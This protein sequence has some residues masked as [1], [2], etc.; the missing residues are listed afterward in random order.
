MFLQKIV[1]HIEGRSL[2]LLS[3]LT[4]LP[5]QQLSAV[6]AI[7]VVGANSSMADNIKRRLDKLPPT[8][9]TTSIEHEIQLALQPF[10]YYA[11]SIKQQA[12]KY[13]IE[14]GKPVH[15]SELDLQLSGAGK[16]NPE[17]AAASLQHFKLKPGDVFDSR[18]YETAK[19]AW[20]DDVR[21]QGYINAQFSEQKVRVNP[22]K[23]SAAISLRLD[24]GK[25]FYFSEVIFAD[26][27]LDADILQKYVPFK[28]GEAYSAKKINALQANLQNSGFFNAVKISPRPPQPKQSTQIPIAV[29]TQPVK[30]TQYSLG[31]GYGTDTGARASANVDWRRLNKRGHRLKT[32]ILGSAYSLDLRN[33][34]QILGDDPAHSHY[35]INAD[36]S[37][38]RLV[39]SNSHGV[40]LSAAYIHQYANWQRRIA[41]NA[42]I[43]QFT[44][45]RKT[46][47]QAKQRSII[48][49]P[50]IAWKWIEADDVNFPFDGYSLNLELLGGSAVDRT[51]VNFAQAQVTAK[52]VKSFNDKQLRLLLRANVGISMTNKL[53]KLPPSLQ[54]MAGGAHSIRGF[55]HHAL[56]PGRYLGVASGELQFKV[57][58]GWYVTSFFDIGRIDNDQGMS[59]GLGVVRQSPIGAISIGVA[60]ALNAKNQPVRLFFS[61]GQDL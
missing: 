49:Y 16:D 42:L 50:S 14:L 48:V 31:V 5:L 28:A 1:Q 34:Y 41:L 19:K 26:D 58:E 21:N 9:D 33:S 59:T 27:Y 39:G 47:M 52:L 60:K 45:D 57:A 36:L 25:R 20:F 2:V 17:L 46:V 22:G 11:V 54:L 29:E 10:G 7:S 12:G 24:T 18:A 43:E 13:A 56:G 61:I 3:L 44:Y 6:E 40:K 51:R 38:R 8:S 4:I 37:R 15:I 53:S 30:S 23:F 35:E 55:R 32:S